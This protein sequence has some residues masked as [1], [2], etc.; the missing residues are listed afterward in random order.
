[1]ISFKRGIVLTACHLSLVIFLCGCAGTAKKEKGM[2]A[3]VLLEPQ[4]LTRFADIPVPAGFKAVPEASYAFESAGMRVGLLKYQGKAT[5][6]QVVGFY[7][8]QM[9]MYSWNLLNVVEYGERLM[10][11]DRE[12]ETCIISILTKNTNIITLTV[13]LG[14]KA[15]KT[16]QKIQ[17]PV[18]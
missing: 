6:D 12:T 9:A 5:A 17:K 1:M 10:N 14:P 16:P 18:K 11:F 2:A 13:T 15:Q 7:K 3:E 8:E 4:A